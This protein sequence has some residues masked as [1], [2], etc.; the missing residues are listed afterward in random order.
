MSGFPAVDVRSIGAGGGSIAWVDDGGLLHVGP[1]S[2][3]SVP[4]PACYGRGGTRPTVTGAMELDPESARDALQ[5]DVGEPLGLAPADSATAVVR[6]ATERMVSAIEEITL[7][8]GIDPASAV[9]VGGGGAA[10]LN[11][12]AIARRLQT[13]LVLVPEVAPSLSAAGAL[14]SDLSRDYTAAFYTST[15]RFDAD[16]VNAVLDKLASECQSFAEGPGESAVEVTVELSA[17]GRYPHQVWDVEVPLLADR[18]AGRQDVDDLRAAFH[19]AHREIFSISDDASEVEFLSWRARVR[20]RLRTD[21]FGLVAD[22]SATAP[23]IEST[24]EVV[25]VDAGPAEAGVM[26]LANMRPGTPLAGPAIIESPWTT[27]VVD[28]GASAELA[29]SGTLVIRP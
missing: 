28:P 14:L 27:I 9:L 5:R 10:G 2:A 24:R 19:A 15:G 23:A 1:A 25:F 22:G 4:G 20:C 13:S 7:R 11:V 29:A 17:E 26:Q 18:F 16:G 8:Q 3:G 6:V 21:A 12:V